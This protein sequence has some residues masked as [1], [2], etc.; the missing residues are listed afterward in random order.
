MADENGMVDIK[1][2]EGSTV[3][4]VTSTAEGVVTKAADIAAAKEAADRAA[5]ETKE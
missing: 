2:P 4:I 5:A 1:I 3:L